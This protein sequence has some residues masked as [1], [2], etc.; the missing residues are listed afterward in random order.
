MKRHV[1]ALL[2]LAVGDAVGTTLE[3]SRR[4][5]KPPVV[6]MVGGGPFDLKPGEWTDDTAMAFALGESLLADP[7]FNA[8]DCAARFLNWYRYGY[9]S[10]TGTCF[11]IGLTTRNALMAFEASGDPFSGDASPASAGNGSIMRLAPVAIAYAGAPDKAELIAAQQSRIT[12]AAEEAVDACR[13]LAFALTH[14]FCSR[15]KKELFSNLF[16]WEGSGEIQAIMR[17]RWATKLRDDIQ[18]S[19]YVVHTLEA[20]F[21][22]FANSSDFEDAILLAANLGDDADT[23]AAVTGQIAGAYYGVDAIPAHWMNKL[24]WSDQLVDLAKSLS[25]INAQKRAD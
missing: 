19:G 18:S 25:Q 24:A 17:G 20:A 6:D 14:A 7:S 3:F 5:S 4:D 2:G 8:A 21:W 23:V 11:D 13:A 1:G 22:A 9:A 12:H 10:C 16:S 15:S